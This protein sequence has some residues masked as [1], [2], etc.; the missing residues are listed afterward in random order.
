MEAYGSGIIAGS[1]GL[2]TSGSCSDSL[3]KKNG[4][5]AQA[6][7]NETQASST[8]SSVVNTKHQQ[9]FVF[10]SADINGFKIHHT[11]CVEHVACTVI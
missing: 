8:S 4:N 2:A 1:L 10:F 3:S 7:C 6:S 5:E 11:I 9:I